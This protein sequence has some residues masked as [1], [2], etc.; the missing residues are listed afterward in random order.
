M[1]SPTKST[2]APMN[3]I[4]VAIVTAVDKCFQVLCLEA[5]KWRIKYDGVSREE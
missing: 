5:C 2:W 4:A 1:S 3:Y